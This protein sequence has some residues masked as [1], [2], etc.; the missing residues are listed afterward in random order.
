MKRFR[1][2]IQVMLSTEV[3]QKVKR[4]SALLGIEREEFVRRA[5][6]AYIQ[7]LYAFAELKQEMQSWEII[8]TEAF[9]NTEKQT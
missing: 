5:V 4:A 1:E 2:D 7:D 3:M 6:L 9:L 8:S